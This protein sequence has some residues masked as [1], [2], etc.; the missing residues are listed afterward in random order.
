MGG[1]FIEQGPIVQ[2][3]SR[4][5][6]PFVYEDKDPRVQFDGKLIVMV[7]SF[8]ASASEIMA[9]AIQDYDRGI[10]VGSASTFGKGTVQ[11]FVDL[12]LFLRGETDLKPLGEVKLTT[13]KFYRINGGAT[14]RKGVIPDIILPDAYSLLEIGEKDREFS[15]KWDEIAPQPYQKW[16]KSYDIN[17]LRQASQARVDANP[18]FSLIEENALR[19]K[20]RQ[21]KEAFSLNLETFQK[22][23]ERLKEEDAK[24]ADIEHEI[25]GL[26][27]SIPKMDRSNVD[28][29]EARQ[30]RWNKFLERLSK[31]PYVYESLMIIKDM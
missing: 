15:L 2:V 28:A 26:E 1:L 18:S 8:S 10:I 31:D 12:D 24:F 9:A 22:N 14:Q 19:F 29:D 5:R 16:S 11:R 4:D 27:V 17:R 3:K 30:D 6:A 25:E 13:Q 21:D 20:S 23:Q 7:N